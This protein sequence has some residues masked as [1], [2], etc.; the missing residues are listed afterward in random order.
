MAWKLEKRITQAITNQYP[1]GNGHATL[2]LQVIA[3]NDNMDTM[4]SCADDAN[5]KAK[6][7]GLK[8]GSAEDAKLKRNGLIAD[9]RERQ[10]YGG[11]KLGKGGLFC[12]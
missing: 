9:F 3:Q 2:K 12:L 6:Q 4:L 1:G 5:Y 10:F 7:N 11:M 8:K